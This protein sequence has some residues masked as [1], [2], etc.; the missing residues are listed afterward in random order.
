V[1]L[2]YQTE[3]EELAIVSARVGGGTATGP[4]RSLVL[5]SVR[6]ARLTRHHVR[7]RRGASVRAALSI[8]EIGEVF[9]KDNLPL[10]EAFVRAALMALPTRIEIEREAEAGGS[11]RD[12]VEQLIG[13]WAR[14]VL[15]GLGLP[16]VKKK[17]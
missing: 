17:P 14:A 5:A 4:L 1:G 15:D 6:L 7:V 3:E 13:E 2:H 11:L 12:E 9:L 16:S 8:A 10:E